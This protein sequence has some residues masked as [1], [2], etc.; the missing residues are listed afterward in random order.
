MSDSPIR[1][2]QF[3]ASLNRFNAGD[4][5]NDL[6]TPDNEQAQN[7]AEIIQRSNPDVLLINEFDFDADG[8]AA[9]LFQENYLSVSQNG[10]DPVEYPFVYVAPSNT[11]IPSG[12]DFNNDGEVGGPG[13]AFGFGFFPGQ[14]GMVLYSK[15]PI[16]TENIRTFQTFLWK[17]MPGALLPDDP[18]TPEPADWYSAEE[19]EVFRLSSKSHW[20]VPISV[21]GETIHVLASH[22]TP[23][24]FDGPEDFNGRRNHDEIRFW[25]DYVTP[26]EGGYIYD[27]S[28]EMGGLE[29]GSKFVIMGDQNADPFDGDSTDD[30]ILQLLD[31]PLVNVSLTPS[32]E[33]GV[34]AAERQHQIN[35]T[36]LGNPALDTADFS[37]DSPGNLRA[38]YVL[39]SFNLEIT[40]TGVV[41]PSS[42][43]VIDDL[44]I[45]G[46][47]YSDTGNIFAASGGTFP[48][49]PPYFEGRFSNGPIWVD[50]IAPWLGLEAEDVLN[51]AAGGAT[52]GREGF[53]PPGLGL[54]SGLDPA[55]PG[56]LDQIDQYVA[57]AGA[58]GLDSDDL[59]VLWFNGNELQVVDPTEPAAI[60]STVIQSVTNI[61]TAV[62]TLESLG[63]EKIAI[64]NAIDIG[65]LPLALETGR[66]PVGTLVA[67]FYNSALALTIDLLEQQLELDIFEIDAFSLSQ[68]FA[69]NPEFG[70]TNVTEPLLDV[71][72]AANPEEFL[73]FDT[74]HYTTQAHEFFAETFLDDLALTPTLET[75]EASSDHRLVYA[76]VVA[77]GDLPNGDRQFVSSLEFLGEV[78]FETGFTFEGT[79]VGGLSGL[80]YNPAQGVYYAL[81]DDRS[82]I[83]DARFYTLNIDLSDSS[84]D[85]GDVEFLDVTALLAEDGEPFASGD[86][87]PEGIAY[88]SIGTVYISS[89]GDTNALIDP[90]VQEFSINTGGKISSLPVPDKFLPTAD[91][92][93]GVRNNLAFES[94]TITPD[95]RFLY[96]ATE[97]ALFQDGPAATLDDGSLVRV[98]QYDLTT[99]EPVKEFL[100]ETDEVA[101]APVPE[102]A[103][104]TNGLVELLAIDNTG[105]LLALERSF[106]VGVGNSIKL[107]EV[108]TQLTTDVSDFDGL[109]VPDDTPFDV[110]PGEPLF[111]VDA[112]ATKELL[113]DFSDLGITLDNSE[114]LAFGPTLP[115]GRQSFFVVSDNNFSDTQFTQFLAFA[116]DLDSTPAIPPTLETPPQIRFGD[117]ENPD[118]DEE[119]DPDDPA[120]YVHPTDSSQSFVITTLK[121]TGLKVFDLEGN[122]IQ[123]ISPAGVRYNNVDLIYGFELGGETMDIAVVSDRANDT[124]AIF[125]IDPDTRQLTDIT[126]A[127]LSVA[128]FSI[129]GVDDGEQTAYGLATY[130][131]IVDGTPYAYVTQADGDKV[132]Q[133]ELADAGDGTITAKVI[134][135][136]QLPV[137]T[138][139]PEDSQ[140][141]GIVIDRETGVGYVA[142]EEVVGI[143]KFNAEP[144]ITDELTLVQPIQS[145]DDFGFEQS[146]DNPNLFV[147]ISDSPLL[148]DIEGLTIYYAADGEGYL[149]ASSQ[150][151]STFAVFDRQTEQYLG[152]FAIEDYL[153]I[154]GVEESDGADIINVPLGDAFP[155][156]LLVVQ[157]GSNEP[158]VVFQD[159]EDG[160]IQNFNANFKYIDWADIVANFDGDLVIDTE[161]YD[162]RNP[163]IDTL[164]NGVASGDVSQDSVVLWARSLRVGD[165]TFEY[166]TSADFDTLSGTVTATVTDSDVP[167]KVEVDG[168][169]SNTEYFYRVT[170]A[171]GEMEV[172]RFVTA[173]EVGEFVGLN[174]GITGDWQQAPPYPSLDSAAASDLDFF[175]K[176][177]DTI[178]ADAE[179]P[180]LPGVTQARTLEEFR[181]KH[182]E[183]VGDRFGANFVSELYKSTAIFAT[184]DDHEVVDNFAGG[185]APGDSPDA[186][187]IGSSPDPLFTDDVEFVNDTQVYEDA[188][189]AYQEYHPIR[190]QFYGET[191]DDRTA[192]ERQ[193]YRTQDFGSDAS[194]F[195][196]DS[197]SFRDDQLEP[198]DLSNPVPFIVE[199][200]DPERTLLGEAQLELLKQDLL[201]AEEQGTTWKFVVI[202]EPIQ[203]FGVVT[204]EDRFEGYAAER[205]ELLKFIDDNDID[206]VVFLAGDF[207]GTLVN[208]LTYQLGPDQEQI[209]TNAFEIVTGPAAFF[210]GR[211]GPAVVNI[212][213]AAGLI[214]PE[215]VA[216]YNSLPIAPDTDDI[217]DDRDDFLE[218]LINEQIAA[219]GYDPIGL[220]NNLDIAEGLIDAT[221]LQGDYVSAHTFSWTEFDI[222][223]N[224][225]ALTVTTF[226][227]D[228]YS[229]AELLA[230][231]EAIINLEPRIVS[232]FVVN[233]D[234]PTEIL[235][236]DGDDRLAGTSADE[237]FLAGDGNDVVNAG[238][239]NDEVEGGDG[240]DRISGDRDSFRE[241]GDDILSGGGD[242]DNIFGRGG[243]DQ[244][245]GGDDDDYLFGNFGDDLLVGGLG[246]DNLNGGNGSD[247]YLFAPGEGT[248]TIRG[249]DVA[250]D[251][252]ALTNGLSAPSLGV[253]QV[254]RH[255]ELSAGSEVLAVLRRVD[256]DDLIAAADTVFV[257]L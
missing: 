154:D 53:V 193:L 145:E 160:E 216:F 241:G 104:S 162:P 111:D 229:E 239:G 200:F 99:G 105:T 86:I 212:A 233:P 242:T 249:F 7:V 170:D 231:P 248:D 33:G 96:T 138:G 76:D 46:D 188:L 68:A 137:P 21:N 106:S 199:T 189:Q 144:G 91:Q 108:R 123:D 140:A 2:A 119:S 71:P 35:D 61:A 118:L 45:F 235:G 228:A 155:N 133:L 148:P 120:I 171:A 222:D 128:D 146:P 122:E 42:D 25:S 226:G 66:G 11:G 250:E 219:F 186:P 36:H 158:A 167:V 9:E 254:G 110:E 151:D 49:S 112:I 4:L 236:T 22:P 93:S 131:S 29:P 215:E 223:A 12:F 3:N 217:L 52:T 169:E 43:T 57:L 6:S 232:Q 80:T 65:T 149:I 51:F 62:A 47:S 130:T 245:F 187:D 38:D 73:F 75:V 143:L 121:N 60:E 218:V 165:L 201:D 82:S 125:R 50:I 44:V 31:N 237:V 95:N 132:A 157:D 115:D 204:A 183:V 13:D 207:H 255:T 39:P 256:A 240:Y 243:N 27:D 202:P 26:G 177:G 17:D 129:F 181:I 176:L 102:D 252:I 8:T 164:P 197:R 224:T 58:D 64:A 206:N 179:T 172:G 20:D 117:S 220:D 126:A 40:D 56:L 180:A 238:L 211:F 24:V 59:H 208:N 10:A 195:V 90:F 98:I 92:S 48:P 194:I 196:L 247:T 34:D 168:L 72:A 94:L 23:P 134:R 227:I 182:A 113:L 19:L 79:E 77:E 15:H 63:A 18:A 16:D 152:S 100:Y 81:S 78:T 209:A 97:N 156:G 101:A 166:S 5:I 136:L 37:D 191:G 88:S 84:L 147:P 257:M 109:T 205:T 69:T 221:L 153:G 54:E 230:D 127:A 190:D 30:A 173:A 67:E 213:A 1:F 253:S 178:F 175:I 85:D 234:L 141:E 161:G 163:D 14:F 244:I 159:P 225:Q 83:N 251:F 89:E 32:S 107:Y 87:D 124:L 103:F 214:S 70:F 203:N 139:D 184:I 116:L 210:D 28:G 198:A 55:L 41:W 135:T 114:A 192:G 150:G 185:A 74:V 246:N 174:F 142:Q